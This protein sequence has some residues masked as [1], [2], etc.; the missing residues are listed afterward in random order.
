MDGSRLDSFLSRA[1]VDS[2]RTCSENVR[3]GLCAVN[4]RVVR[5]PS[6]R[7][8][9]GDSVSYMGQGVRIPPPFVAMLN[10]PVGYETTMAE[11]SQRRTVRQLMDGMPRGCRPCGRLDVKTGGLLLVTNDGELLHRLSHPRWGVTREYRVGLKSKPDRKVIDALGR[12]MS[13][14]KGEVCRPVSVRRSGARELTLVLDRGRYHEV[15]R[16]MSAAHLRMA[17]LE[18]TAYGPVRLE[19]VARGS[20]KRLEGGILQRLYG[21]VGLTPP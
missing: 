21:E 5:D 14:G 2:R 6:H 17:F 10:K 1:G 18:R 16:L 19:G 12:G 13:I 9:E 8:S 15:R 7:L 4:G 11:R 20:W 3:Q